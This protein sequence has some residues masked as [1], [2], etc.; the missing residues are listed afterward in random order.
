MDDILQDPEDEGL[1]DQVR[2]HDALQAELARAR[3]ELDRF[4]SELL[5]SAQEQD[6][7]A[8]QEAAAAGEQALDGTAV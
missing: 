5:L 8:W 2:A 7:R 3:H 4:K 1:L 6:N